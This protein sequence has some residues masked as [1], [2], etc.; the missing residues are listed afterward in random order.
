V[1][2]EKQ[3]F[4]KKYM[5]ITRTTFLI[6]EDGKI[7]KIIDKPDTENHTAQILQAWG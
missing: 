4:G 1:W 5:G 2:G 7:K 3:M 6:D